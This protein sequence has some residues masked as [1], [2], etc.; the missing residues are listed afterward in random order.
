MARPSELRTEVM[1]QLRIT[2]IKMSTPEWDLALMG[3]PKKIKN[4]AAL[5]YARVQSA[6]LRLGNAILANIRDQLLVNEKNLERGRER[7]AKALEDIGKVERV[8]GAISSFLNIVARIVT[9]V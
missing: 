9:L 2:F 4:Q 8:L 7:V 6:R 5:E 3:K 1:K